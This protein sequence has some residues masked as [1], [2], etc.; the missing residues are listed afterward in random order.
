MLHRTTQSIYDHLHCI[1]PW[2]ISTP[3]NCNRV[4]IFIIIKEIKDDLKLWIIIPYQW[5]NNL[6]E[7]EKSRI[8]TVSGLNSKWITQIQLDL[9]TKIHLFLIFYSGFYFIFILFK[10]KK[11][12]YK[13]HKSHGVKNLRGQKSQYLLTNHKKLMSF[14]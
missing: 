14:N 4:I 5:D 13:G 6:F 1:G 7:K 10:M 8:I 2:I 9:F 11:K 12:Q 3:F